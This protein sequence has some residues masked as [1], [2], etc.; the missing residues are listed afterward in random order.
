[1]KKKTITNI[2]FVCFLVMIAVLI[3]VIIAR[4]GE[5]KG[6][7]VHKWEYTNNE[8]GTHTKTCINCGI[9]R[10]EDHY[11]EPGWGSYRCKFCH[12]WMHGRAD[13]FTDKEQMQKVMQEEES[14]YQEAI[15]NWEEK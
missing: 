9:K 7:C 10:Q 6:N 8:D 3:V 2:V 4:Y 5:T 15:K 11:P 13:Q 12:A 14:W 1:M